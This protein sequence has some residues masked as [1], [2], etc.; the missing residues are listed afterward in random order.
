LGEH[1][2]EPGVAF[3]RQQNQS[4]A[5]GDAGPQQQGEL[6]AQGGNLLVR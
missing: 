5:A 3:L 2:L 6:Q 1:L 4:V